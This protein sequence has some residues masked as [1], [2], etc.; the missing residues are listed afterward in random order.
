MPRNWFA[1]RVLLEMVFFSSFF[2][3]LPLTKI[4]RAHLLTMRSGSDWMLVPV[5]PSAWVRSAGGPWDEGKKEGEKRARLG[6]N[7]VWLSRERGSALVRV[8]TFPLAT[9]SH[10]LGGKFVLTNPG[11]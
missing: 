4:S 1:R 7:R 5:D 3:S 6:P 2:S 9:S 11:S 10:D 8:S